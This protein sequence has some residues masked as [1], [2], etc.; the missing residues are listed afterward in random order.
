M[1]QPLGKRLQVI[2]GEDELHEIQRVA[3]RHKLTVAEWVR[4]TLRAA[5]RTDPRGDPARKL[6]VV[7]T[8]VKQSFPNGEGA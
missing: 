6:A 7:R 2:F 4:Q 3:R 8:A 5:R 1:S